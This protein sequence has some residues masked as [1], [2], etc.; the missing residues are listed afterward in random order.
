MYICD[1]GYLC[2]YYDIY[3]TYSAIINF[4]ALLIITQCH[5]LISGVGVKIATDILYQ[6]DI[7]HSELPVSL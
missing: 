1:S 2:R 5:L 4:F 6:S 3:P 7:Y